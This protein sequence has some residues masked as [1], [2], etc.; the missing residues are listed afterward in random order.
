MIK[1]IDLLAEV[2]EGT[3]QKYSYK[4]DTKDDNGDFIIMNY[5]FTTDS[6]VK[7][8]VLLNIGNEPLAAIDDYEM[9]V[10]FG[11]GTKP[12]I[13]AKVGMAKP[14]FTK[15][16]NKGEVFRV[17][18]TVIDIVKNA[19]SIM[20]EEDRPIRYISFKPEKEKETATGFEQSNQRLELYLAYIR[21]NMDQV[22][23]I[24]TTSNAVEVVLK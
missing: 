12:S 14:S 24:K 2:G 5:V 23:S 4:L 7:Y 20:K 17:M 9:T 15:V 10:S 22:Q 18:A 19:M 21:K 13:K 8:F 6:N 3:S 1:L 16:V 11:V